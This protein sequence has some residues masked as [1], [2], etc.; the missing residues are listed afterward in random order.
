MKTARNSLHSYP[1]DMT[2]VNADSPPLLVASATAILRRESKSKKQQVAV[3]EDSNISLSPDM[4][5]DCV[6]NMLIVCG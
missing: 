4:T 5:E 6:K 2:D 1:F 3:L